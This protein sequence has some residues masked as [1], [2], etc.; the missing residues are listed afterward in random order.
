MAAKEIFQMRRRVLIR[1]CAFAKNQKIVFAHSCFFPRL[2]EMFCDSHYS[3]SWATL[4][5]GL[6]PTLQNLIWWHFRVDTDYTKNK[7]YMD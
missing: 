7:G 1:F 5:L 2:D 4:R 3:A 6:G